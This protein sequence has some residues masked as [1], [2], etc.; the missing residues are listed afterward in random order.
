MSVHVRPKS[1]FEIDVARGAIEK[2]GEVI[3]K[4]GRNTA[5]STTFVPVCLGGIYRTPQVAGVTTLRIKAGNANDTAAGSGAREITLEGLDETGT[6]VTETLATAGESASSNTSN[7]YIRLFRAYVSASGTYT[8]QSTG[9]HAANIVI[10]NSA[11]TEDWLTIDSTGFPKSQSEVGCYTVPLGKVAY[12]REFYVNSD[13]SKL[14]TILIF[15]RQNILETSAP[16]TAA[17][18]VEHITALNQPFQQEHIGVLGPFPALTDIGVLAKF[19][20]GTG[21]IETTFEIYLEDA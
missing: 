9:S 11:G 12:I 7:T 10:E 18:M 5:V 13:T 16:Y 3:H 8:D 19:A 21:V 1:N 4:F 20:A 15:Q 6:Y 17:R 2:N 14:A